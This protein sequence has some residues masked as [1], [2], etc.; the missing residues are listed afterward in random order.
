MSRTIIDLDAAGLEKFGF[1]CVKTKSHLGYKAKKAWFLKQVEQGLTIKQAH[2][3]GKVVGFIE[4]IPAEHAW[5]PVKA[6]G[7]LFIH[8]LSVRSKK[9][10][11]QGLATKLVKSVI[12]DAKNQRKSGVAVI[13]S[14]KSW[15]AGK[16]IFLMNGFMH[17]TTKERYDLLAFPLIQAGPD[18]RLG[19]RTQEVKNG[20]YDGLHLVY[21]AQCPYSASNI[22]ELKETAKD[23]GFDLHLHELTTAEEAQNAPSINSTFTL[24][25]NGHI[26]EDHYISKT[27]FRNILKKIG[28]S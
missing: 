19:F 22:N 6:H 27:R 2:V 3:D 16:E 20:E 11:Q 28:K 18:P 1:S 4:Y 21:S 12:E 26:L 5:R 9:H 14:E 17:I 24:I 10:R 13:T 23:S 25:H 8:C 7:Y 15:M